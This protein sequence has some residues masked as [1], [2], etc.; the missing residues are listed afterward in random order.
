[1]LTEE[2]ERL[3]NTVILDDIARNG[4]T[5]S[6][7]IQKFLPGVKIKQI[8]ALLQN[9][10][11]EGLLRSEVVNPPHDGQRGGGMQRR[12]YFR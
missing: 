1:M 8:R 5:Y 6:G 12:Y 10:E 4:R 11:K 7:A 9:M 3:G 2:L